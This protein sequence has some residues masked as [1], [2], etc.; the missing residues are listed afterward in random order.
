MPPNGESDATDPAAL[1]FARRSEAAKRGAATKGTAG[2]REAAKKAAATKGTAGLREAAKKAHET[3]GADRRSA[4]TTKGNKTKGP[5]RLREAGIKGWATRRRL[6]AE[7]GRRAGAAGERGVADAEQV[8]GNLS[9][10]AAAEIYADYHKVFPHWPDVPPPGLKVAVD[11]HTMGYVKEAV[12]REASGQVLAQGVAM[13]TLNVPGAAAGPAV[14][15]G[16]PEFLVDP[17]M[18]LTDPTNQQ[19]LRD[20]GITDTQYAQ[21]AARQDDLLEQLWGRDTPSPQAEDRHHDYDFA[22]QTACTDMS[23]L[24]PFPGPSSQGTVHAAASAYGFPQAPAPHPGTTAHTG[25]LASPSPH[26]PIAGHATLHLPARN[27]QPAATA[28]H[29]TTPVHQPSAHPRDR[30]PSR[31]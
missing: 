30:Q 3:K 15:A 2:L 1:M 18:N 17:G 10:I 5:E 31:R 9:G 19:F 23:P 27:N 25:T 21:A 24:P 11:S 8:R 12:Y 22:R 4:A 16:V 13:A 20:A 28:T 26:N 6:A 29:P 14:T 7:E